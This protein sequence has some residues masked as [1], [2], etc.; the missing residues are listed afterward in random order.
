MRGVF[1]DTGAWFALKCRTD[2]YHQKVREFFRT[3]EKGTVCFTSDYVADEAVTLVRLRLKNHRVAVQLAGE[4]FGEKAA[5][6]V[7]VSPEH[8]RRAL[9]IFKK[10][11]DQDFSYTDCTSFA[12][13]EAL[14]IKE[15]LAFDTHFTFEKFGFVQVGME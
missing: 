11:A 3:M 14:G 4:L 7:F 6:L 12:V 1:V 13:M 2:P 5:R 15:A 10:Y 9:E 8:H